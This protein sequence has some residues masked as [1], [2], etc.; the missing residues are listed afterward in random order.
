MKKKILTKNKSF[1]DV[2]AEVKAFF[3]LQGKILPPTLLHDVLIKIGLPMVKLIIQEEDIEL[4]QIPSARAE[5]MESPSQPEPKPR[6]EPSIMKSETAK[7]ETSIEESA[8]SETGVPVRIAD[9]EV[10]DIVE[11]LSVVE[12]M[13]DSFMSPHHQESE[14]PPNRETP[15]ISIRLQG[16]EE[17]QATETTRATIVSDTASTDVE[18]DSKAEI[19]TEQVIE[20][21][22]AIQETPIDAE[23]LIPA[24][25]ASATESPIITDV[26]PIKLTSAA[27][28][29]PLIEKKA[30]I[31]GEEE[32]GKLNLITKAGLS[33]VLTEDL[34]TPYIYEKTIETETYRVK[35]K[36]WSFDQASLLSISRRVFYADVDVA[37]IVYS[38]VD[39]W[40]FQS[41][42][43]WLKEASTSSEH[44]PPL[45]IVANK[46]D[47]RD[48]AGP[49]AVTRDEGFALAETLAKFNGIG[50]S[51][52]PIGFIETSCTTGEGVNA[53]FQLVAELAVKTR[54]NE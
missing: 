9:T 50:D 6:S 2:L 29:K 52:H 4:E 8:Y 13:S 23:E 37:I 19:E 53:L 41:I 51:L 5:L 26:K 21:E 44:M 39:R 12:S 22:E 25:P 30:I 14:E 45:V 47:L 3:K 15:K 34:S 24:P 42:D 33:P 48:I 1:D 17:I 27:M 43:F 10:T 7:V 35:L 31:L 20:S 38:A 46:I 16:V 28:V 36:V 32:V 54:K 18:Q 49:Q 40:S 11:A